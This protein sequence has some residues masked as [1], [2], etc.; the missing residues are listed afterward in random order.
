[1]PGEPLAIGNPDDLPTR[2]RAAGSRVSVVRRF[3]EKP[4]LSQAHSLL[5]QGGLW[6]TMVVVGR[7]SSMWRLGKAHVPAQMYH[8]E[9]YLHALPHPRSYTLLA[10]HYERLS[11][12]D[13]SRDI[14]QV[15]AGLSVVPVIGSGWF[16]CGTPERLVD[17]LVATD[18]P[19]GILARISHARR[20]DAAVASA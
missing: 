3:V 15:A 16:D 1:V 4:P 7:V 5:Q 17:W 12:A 9:R 8:F 13:L 6:N 19:S 2:R 18:D 14:L 11:P 10:R 20:E